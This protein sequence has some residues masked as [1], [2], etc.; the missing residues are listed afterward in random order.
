MSDKQELVKDLQSVVDRLKSL[1]DTVIQVDDKK[2]A[3]LKKTLEHMKTVMG[4]SSPKNFNSKSPQAEHLVKTSVIDYVLST[5][6]DIER[7]VGE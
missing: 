5:M 4:N 3:T 2:W 1:Q 7:A 6:Q